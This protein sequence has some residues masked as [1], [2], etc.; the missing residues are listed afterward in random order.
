MGLGQEVTSDT[1]LS[2]IRYGVQCNNRQDQTPKG[3][4]LIFKGGPICERL[5]YNFSFT[6]GGAEIKV[7]KI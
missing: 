7:I 2:M 4:G 1:L 5:W 6:Q 3:C